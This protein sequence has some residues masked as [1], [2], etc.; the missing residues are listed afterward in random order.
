MC[1]AT[2]SSEIYW[3]V[4]CFVCFIPA[5]KAARASLP[6]P[7][8]VVESS[9]VHA[10]SM[11][12]SSNRWDLQRFPMAFLKPSFWHRS[13]VQRAWALC[14]SKG[15][16]CRAAFTIRVFQNHFHGNGAKTEAN[17]KEHY[18]ARPGNSAFKFLACK[19]STKVKCQEDGKNKGTCENDHQVLQQL[20]TL[21]PPFCA[22]E[23]A[24]HDNYIL[25]TWQGH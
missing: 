7:K 19:S 18:S 21:S 16:V 22:C 17:R 13:P 6:A 9:E 8:K 3:H 15:W 12:K 10:F 23:P 5:S 2:N 14:L 4:L 25:H 24:N 1:H 20:K 11:N